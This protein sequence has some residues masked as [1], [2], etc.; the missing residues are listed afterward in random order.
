[1]QSDQSVVKLPRPMVRSSPKSP[2]RIAGRHHARLRHGRE[3]SQSAEADILGG[4]SVGTD[5]ADRN[6]RRKSVETDRGAEPAADTGPGL[7]SDDSSRDDCRTENCSI[8]FSHAKLGGVGTIPLEESRLGRYSC[9]SVA[10]P[11]PVAVCCWPSGGT[12]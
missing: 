11:V 1:M 3:P 8:R 5:S 9:V 6:G 10:E 7:D 12:W 4:L 2:N